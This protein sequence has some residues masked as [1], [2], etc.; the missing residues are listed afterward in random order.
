[1]TQKIHLMVRRSLV[2]VSLV[3][4]A[5]FNFQK[6]YA[7][8]VWT[9]A[10]NST[11]LT[12]ANWSG[13]VAPGASGGS[14]TAWAQFGSADSRTAI[15]INL[16]NNLSGGSN[17]MS[18]GAIEVASGRTVATTFSNS[19]T[20]RAGLITLNG[21]TVNS[22][23]NVILSNSSSNLMSFPAST[24]TTRLALGGSSNLN[25]ICAAGSSSTIGST[26]SIADTIAGTAPLTFLGS[27]TY[28][29]TTASGNNGG[30]L[31]LTGSNTFSGGITVGSSSSTYK[32]G[33]L[34]LNSLTAISN[35][36]GN[37]ITINPNSQLYLSSGSTG[38][39]TMGNITLNLNGAGNGVSATY[40]A[41][42]LRTAAV[43]YTWTGPI[44]LA[45]DATI[46][47][48][49][50]LTLSGN[51]T[52][53]GQLTKSGASAMTVSGAT[54]AGNTWGG[55]TKITAGSITVPSGSTLGGSGNVT[56]S[57]V[58]S[59]TPTTITFASAS[60]TIGNLSSSFDAGFV[61]AAV[62]T[63]ALTAGTLTINQ[64]SNT[65]FGDGAGTTQKSII[66]GA[67][68]IVKNGTGTLT[69]TSGGSTFTGGLTINNGEL[70]FNPT[71]SVAMST[72]PVT[73]NGGTLSTTGITTASLT[74]SLGNLNLTD[75]T[76]I[77]L[78]SGVVN[79]LKFAN[80]TGSW[81]SGKMINVTG[82]QGLFNSTSGTKGKLLI[83]TTATSLSSAQLAQIQF[84]DAN[85][86]VFSAIQLSTGEVV[87]KNAPPV[88][89]SVVPN[90]AN[91]GASVTINGTN[92]NYV[93]ANNKVFFGAA[94]ATI[95]SGTTTSLTVTVPA[96]ASYAPIVVLNNTTSYSGIE[97]SAF[98]PTFNNS[99]FIANT[100]NFKPKVD[101]TTGTTPYN[102]A[103][104]DLD[105][106]GKAD[107]VVVNRAS[108]TASIYRNLKTVNNGSIT[109]DSFSS[110]TT[111]SGGSTL[112]NVKL[113]DLD[114]DG[115]PEI[116][117]T[118]AGDSRVYYFKNNSTSGSISFA[119]SVFVATATTPAVLVLTDVDGDGKIDIAVSEATTNTL[120]ILRN[121]STAAGT[122]SFAAQ[123]TFA[124]GTTPQGLAVADF[125]KDGKPDLAVA[126]GGTNTVSVFI[127]TAT[128][129]TITS[130]SL[131]SGVTFTTG[132]S[133]APTD[134]QAADID[135]DG[136]PDLIVSNNSLGN[137]SILQNTISSTSTTI[138]SGAFASNVDFTI[139][140][141][142]TGLYVGDLNGDGKLDIAVNNSGS[143]TVSVFRN[144]ATPGTISSGSLATR[145]DL[146]VGT[147]PVGANIA[148]L[149]GDGKPEILVANSGS[150]KLSVFKNYPLPPVSAITGTLTLCPSA[151]TT[152]SDATTGGTWISV[153]PSI[154]TISASTGVVTSIA[155]DT[156][157]I[158]YRVIADGDTNF[159]STVVTVN[160]FPSV[161]AIGGATTVCPG[162]TITLTDATAGG[163]WS[164]TNAHATINSSGDVTGVTAGL[165]TV[166]YVVTSLGCSTTVGLA[167]AVSSTP[168]A[169]TITGASSICPSASTTFS[170]VITG[171]VWSSST[172]FVATVDT[173]SGVVT[174]VSSGTA[175]I[176]YTVTTS[177]GTAFTTK[178]I[179]VSSIPSAGTI[180]GTTTVCTGATTAL[181]NATPSGTWSSATPSVAT[182]DASGVV[183]GVSAGNVNIS[184]TVS[185]ACG[186]ASTSTSVTVNTVPTAPAAIA[187]TTSFC[188]STTT[189]L[190]D[191]TSGGAWSSSNPSVAT[192]DASG[193]VTAVAAGS[194]D[195]SYTLTNS[196]G[197]TSVTATVTVNPAPSVPPAIGG[198]STVCVG[199]TTNLT[200]A[201]SGGAWSSSSTTNATIDA[202]TGV[203]TGVAVGST[204]ITYT[205]TNSCGSNFNT[206]SI[207]VIDIPS[208]PAAI[209][210]SAFVCTSATTNLTD[211]T[212]GGT[213]SSTTTSVA[214]IT[215]GGVV[216]GV[217][218]G[219]SVITYAVSNVCGSSY[220]MLTE[221]VLAAPSAPA[222]ITGTTTVCASSTT[223][224]ADGT[225]G[226]TWSSVT[227]S[228]ATIDASGVVTG[229]SSGTSVIS[230]TLSNICGTAASTTTVT[231]NPLPSAGTITGTTTVNIGGA[232][233]TLSDAVTGGTW[234]SASPA[235]ATISTGGV[236]TAL[237]VGTSVISYAVT[238]SC[239]TAYATTSVTSAN[240]A[241]GA[242]SGTQWNTFSGVSAT[243]P[244]TFTVLPATTTPGSSF[245]TISQWNRIGTANGTGTGF[246][247][248]QSWSLGAN[249]AT[250][251]SDHKY[252]YF[253]ITNG[254]TAE[255]NVSN[256]SISTQRSG[257]GPTSVQMQYN[258][259]SFGDQ[260]FGSSASPSTSTT[261]LSFSGNVCIPPSQTDTFKLY[262]WGG[263]AAGG[264]LRVINGTSISAT[265]V[266]GVGSLSS[267]APS[268]S[269][270]VCAGSSVVFTGGTPSF[271]LPPYTYSWSG[272]AAYTSTV[273]SPTISSA[274]VAASGT[275]TFS[276]TDTLGCIVSNTTAAVVNA[277]PTAFT[278][279]G[280]GSYCS[281]GAGVAVG[282]SG[283]QS[284]VDY[285]LYLNGTPTGST[286]PGTGSSITFGSQTGIGT[287]TASATNSTTTCFANM[288]GSVSVSLTP[289][290]SAGTITGTS[291]VCV[292]S[293]TTLSDTAIGGTWSSSNPSLATVDAT[294]GVV[295]G[296]AAGSPNISYTV[297]NVCGSATVSVTATINT[298]PS[299]PSAITGTT[300]VCVGA[301]TALADG[302][303]GGTWSSVSTGVA[304]IDASGTVTGV[305]AGTSTISYALT[306]TCGTV[307]A[308]T[309]VTV[310]AA[311]TAGTITGTPSVCP[312]ATTTLSD[313]V[314]GG[315]WSSA[316]TGTA[317]VDASTGVVT[318]VA[319]GTTTISYTV[320]TSC[321][322]DVA[323]QSLT[324]NPLPTVGAISGA[325]SVCTGAT[326]T[327]TNGTSGGA[328][329]SATPSVATI[330]A[331]GVITGV[332]GGS[333]VIT[334]AVTNSCGT[335]NALKGI[336]V[337]AV[338][339]T[340]GV[341]T[342]TTSICLGYTTTLGNSV[343][344]GTWSSS[345]TSIATANT[346]TGVVSALAAGSATISYTIANACGSNTV[347]TGVTVNA[348]QWVGGSSGMESDWNTAGNW[349]CGFVPGSSDDATIPSGT[350]YVPVIAASAS[351]TTRNLTI[352]SGVT[353]TVSSGATLNVKGDL[354]SNAT[355]AGAGSCVLSGSSAQAI[356]GLGKIEN[357]ELNNSAGATINT[358]AR[359]RITGV[360]TVT[361]GT[362]VT[363]DS[364]VLVSDTFI[365][366]RVAPLP[367]SG[368]SISGNVQVQQYITN[369][370]RAYRFWGTPFSNSI[371][372]SQLTDKID[373]TGAGGAANGFTTTATNQPSAYRYNPLYGNSSLSA[374]PGW[375][376]FTSALGTPDSNNLHRYQG[377]R[378]YYRGKKGEGLGFGPY[379]VINSTTVSQKGLL[380]QGNQDITLSK[381]SS[382]TQDYNMVANP[383]A[384]P[385]DVGTVI[386]NAA[387]A[388]R[389]NGA[390][391]YIWNP[392]LG[393]AGQFQAI[394]YSISGAA[395][396]YYLQENDAF[397][398]RA[399]SNGVQLNFTESDKHATMSSAYSLMKS[400]NEFVSLYIYDNNY[401]PYDMLNV[402][403]DD[404]AANEEDS[405]YDAAKLQG[406]D[407]N[408]YSLSADNHKLSIDARPYKKDNVIPLGIATAYAQ[409]YIIRAEN[410]NVPTGGKVYL[411][412]KLLKQYV[413]LQQ[414][415]E[416]RF[417]VTANAATQGEN[418]FELSMEPAEVATVQAGK[419]LNMTIA[420]NPAS[421][422]V[423]ISFTQAAKS[424]V[425]I[426]V[427]D[428]SGISVI[429]KD[430]GSLQSGK[431]TI[432]L[433]N[434]ASG[435]YMVE[436]TSGDKKVV[437]RLIKE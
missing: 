357:L 340:P 224:L 359:V 299:A 148:D 352:A 165:D 53:S 44:N 75:N 137:I 252:I 431:C 156:V 58:G 408:F 306:N 254:S 397:Q 343:S 83:G 300:T 176:T 432:S 198:G 5:L 320:T 233:S 97:D 128:A 436:L 153:R 411:H 55:G 310:N 108:N 311:P 218:A 31:K 223:L 80:P 332:T 225:A 68:A 350:T 152:L 396:P 400:V 305:A 36:S 34:D 200:N 99:V 178:G 382:T 38:T 125:N 278:M 46:V 312:A 285:Q 41:G 185:T 346:T 230:Y 151:N 334:Y 177:C 265:Y 373:I 132:T 253:T 325:S 57:Q 401:H 73:L 196:C 76:T 90:A 150:A 158:L 220:A 295:T 297:S 424:Q 193:L 390:A 430:L 365:V 9:G 27:G 72:C 284:G 169:G 402:K 182:V 226:G 134:I 163:T 119:S 378:V 170:D 143:G 296:V 364:L 301:T 387:A 257:T 112:V 416:Y 168:S 419:G 317:T 136:K 315:T 304:T 10:S 71:G 247:N 86:I 61:V 141:G 35:T 328:W 105:G 172:P 13:A 314:S 104:G 262:G 271:G 255:V 349:S 63:L 344:G 157:T 237:T 78:G 303:S 12:T 49:G 361:S 189:S 70:R 202:T 144:T 138:T 318:G 107:M 96:Y 283:S 140:T 110:P 166:F 425:N 413:L 199:G 154:A 375:L 162:A 116:L 190:S 42:A 213:W 22:V 367:G 66:T 353:V 274:T 395:N 240:L 82:W 101:F 183:T 370:R 244:S 60:Q 327:F 129:G 260:N 269:A 268:S 195:I 309:T 88:I 417:S 372:L 341:I 102:V 333:S 307:A 368:A 21:T 403:F 65:T 69:L 180:T 113:A 279:T 319:A 423:S 388:G 291:T 276:V 118:S 8:F 51:I 374:D 273:Q 329:T 206:L 336:T 37:D 243:G 238:N 236:V 171:G 167:M 263:S 92:F 338:P 28:D 410:L 245:V 23:A 95:T 106:D 418:R 342:G 399:T 39:Y 288:T 131:A 54:G 84:T 286:V 89:T 146:T 337:I 293:T 409:D 322:T 308:T 339:A 147:A 56:F 275:Y 121:T 117:F 26:I 98:T 345:A 277:L 219:T 197:N 45:S 77:D 149:D 159:A 358:G 239:G 221:T 203:V 380:N 188:I 30:V 222:S 415:T 348:M 2:L 59:G 52:G 429:E 282:L 331:S 355:I 428:L 363:S 360:L 354:T 91:P 426:R 385:V 281:G 4:L 251:Q 369:G 187:G 298:V 362:L 47:A 234:S 216:T 405:K 214:T 294:T 229:V 6:S 87:P 192:V 174:G 7:Q 20:T 48:N 392:F 266:T 313:A 64:T 437:Q 231:V 142:P 391:F 261:T 324:V 270:P 33:I 256:V 235:V 19:S 15:G 135:G 398:V 50:A 194:A 292:G 384:S 379:V 16:N 114:G 179:T 242:I 228:V 17:N 376:P 414:G 85:G 290:P 335:T 383:Y 267:T 356:N 420:P 389:I 207:S 280:G 227:T 406:A 32:S 215:S 321:G 120:G 123:V 264:T 186:S 29:A 62:Q 3:T 161:A 272:P 212:S 145:V 130:S 24:A 371:P 124:T 330:N 155:A 43:A 160:P 205:V 11:W 407:L 249:L 412:D 1:M 209:G 115:K 14:T 248:T 302:T 74:I 366:S 381:G 184:Y 289:L 427:M 394:A 422:Q 347:T 139:A 259:T 81:T 316:A 103:V 67:G 433:S 377:I 241:A 122:I 111:V 210:G 181:A 25:I 246:Y 204:T 127:N 109:T 191:A 94:Q 434:L 435:I 404:A 287:Y 258:S 323:T 175:T 18:I 250:A 201:T 173:A 133:S 126:N 393:V 211:A 93:T 232:T 164:I 40:G 79:T 208:A 100:L 421:D 326:T 217:S 386:F 351:G